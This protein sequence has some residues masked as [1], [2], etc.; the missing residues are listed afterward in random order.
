MIKKL[1]IFIA[2]LFVFITMRA[3]IPS[4]YYDNAANK[5]GDI[6]KSALHTIIKTNDSHVSYTPG[7]WNAY[8]KTDVKPGTNYI[9]DIYSDVPNG[10]PSYQYTYSTNQCG[11]GGQN[12]EGDCYNREHLWAQSWTSNDAT[13]KTDLHHV[14]PT[15]KYVNARRGNYAFGEV[16]SA[17]ETFS[18]GGKIGT[19]TVSGFSGTV[20]EPIDEFKGDIA[21]ALMYV[22]VRYYGDDDSWDNSD[23]TTKSVIKSWAMTM[24]LDWHKNDPVSDKERRRNDSVY[25]IQHNR[26]PFIDHPEYA[27]KIWDPTWTDDNHI[28]VAANSTL[29]GMAFIGTAAST[30]FSAQGYTNGQ[31]VSSAGIGTDVSVAF[32]QGTNGSNAPKYYNT[33]SAIR[34]YSGNYFEVSTSS[35][36]RIN[37]IKLTYGTDDQNN[38]IT[39]NVGSFD[40]DRWTGSAQSVRFTIGGS[41]GHRRI[42]AISVTLCE[43]DLNNGSTAS[44]TAAPNAGYSFV[45]WTIN[46]VAVSSN[47]TYSFTVTGNANLVAN[48]I[49]NNVTANTSV[50]SLTVNGTITVSSNVKLTVAGPITQLTGSTILV[51]NGGQ[52]VCNNSVNIRMRKSITAWNAST[53]KGWYAIS[54]PV[55]NQAFSGDNGVL[56]LTASTHN[57]YRYDETEVE[58]EEYRDSHNIFSSFE[59]ARGYLYRTASN[60]G[61]IEFKGNNNVNAFNYPL[62]FASANSSLKGF[63]LIGN[64]FAQEITWANVTKT[65][66]AT[67]GYYI[68]EESGV[69]QGKWAL[70][71]SSVAAIAPMQAFL[72]QARGINPSVTISR[73]AAKDAAGDDADNIMFAVS[74]SRQSDEAYVMFKEGWGLNKIAHRND[75]IP[76]LYVIDNDE[77]YAVADIGNDTKFI[78]LGL[79]VA[80]TGHYSLSCKAHGEVSYL[81]VIDKFTGDDVDMLVEDRYDFIASE[82]DMDDRFVVRLERFTAD[83]ESDN[84]V[85]AYQNGSDI[86]V[87]GNGE[88]QIFDMMG[89][90]VSTMCVNGLETLHRTS[91]QSGVYIFRLIGCD[92]K[93]QKIVIN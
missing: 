52:L 79:K 32:N 83:A 65:N 80:A 48:F 39:T 59:N 22:S 46:S 5:T 36:K 41:S 73:A 44:V 51:N 75:E 72:V 29:C 62:S 45:N 28:A 26:N 33:G 4:G 16:S 50:P 40:T 24:L 71:T 13:E 19:N 69:N 35:D 8:Q 17:S 93:T 63:N 53:K 81:H 88:L 55:N 37:S 89:R 85:F 91:L 84:S 78:S 31:V 21:R 58:W 68:L 25:K 61:M 30:D 1:H 77:R 11:S 86:V 18:N 74:N 27:R 92:V 2:L 66:V 87:E 43:S 82:Q 23:M 70:V 9:W 60:S 90:L 42:K 54:S 49:S 14:F 12:V 6:L 67:D 56:N 7:L 3:Q 10:T 47:A 64:P 20:Y 38:A 57:I 34:C 76:M 15:D